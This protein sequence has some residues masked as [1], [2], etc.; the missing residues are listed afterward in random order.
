[1]ALLHS[2]IGPIDWVMTAFI[3]LTVTTFIN[4]LLFK[5][6]QAAVRTH[7]MKHEAQ[8]MLNSHEQ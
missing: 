3:V 1:P 5:V 4:G 7:V 2:G 6:F 8:Q